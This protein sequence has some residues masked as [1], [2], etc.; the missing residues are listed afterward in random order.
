MTMNRMTLMKGTE[1]LVLAS[2]VSW[3]FKKTCWCRQQK[4][5][6]W[7]LSLDNGISVISRSAENSGKFV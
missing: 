3:L 6:D 5:Q 7:W 2:G 1:M 4:R